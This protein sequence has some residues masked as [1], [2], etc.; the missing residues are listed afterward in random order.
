MKKF[1]VYSDDVRIFSNE[2]D[3]VKYLSTQRTKKVLSGG[4]F[5]SKLDLIE[6]ETCEIEILEESIASKYLESYVD[7][8]KRETKLN[9]VLGD[10]LSQN[11]EK[12]KTMF[13]E[14]A[15][16]DTNKNKFLSQLEVTPVE[17]KSLSKLISSWSG[18]LFFVD[19]SVEWYRAILNLHS[20]RKINDSY[21]REIFYSNGYTSRY[22]N[23]K[24]SEEQKRNFDEA[25]KTINI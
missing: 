10:T 13:S 7:S 25:K 20:F 17:K 2:K 18:Y 21:T 15:K 14:L 6:I 3:L 5:V 1:I 24:V 16:D 4:K 9:S 22:Q 23:V 12:F 8:Q 19:Y 11:F